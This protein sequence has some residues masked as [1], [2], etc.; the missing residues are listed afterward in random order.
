MAIKGIL[1]PLPR[2][3]ITPAISSKLFFWQPGT[4]TKQNAYTDETLATPLSNPLSADSAGLFPAIYLDP[5]L[6]YKVALY[7]STETND[8]PTGT[9]TFSQDNVYLPA[10]SYLFPLVNGGRLTLTSATPVTTADVSAATTLF[11]TPYQGN[12]L[13][14]Y[15]S[16]KTAWELLTFSEISIPLVGLTAS[17]P[18]DVWAYNNSGTAALELTA[19]TS[20]TA[21]AT[22]LALQDGVLVKSGTATRRYLGTVY[23]DAT[24][25][26]TDDTAAKRYLWNYYHRVRRSLRVVDATASWSY[27]TNTVRQANGN[28]ANQV[29]VVVGVAEA[30]LDLSQQVAMTNTNAAWQAYAS[31]GEDSTTT[32]ATG[33]VL[34]TTTGAGGTANKYDLSTT[35]LVKYPAIGRHFYAWV[36]ASITAATTT[37]LGTNGALNVAGITGSIEG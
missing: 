2:L 37:W 25:G 26:Q 22:A 28:P 12:R 15:N 16:T 5:A 11:F 33:V 18:Y 31:I 13:A 34:T 8:P 27:S 9:P 32:I 6:G 17:T 21:R 36:E 7:P 1:L 10:A 35:R 19:W 20:A 29:D 23:I 3:G 4:T 14:L 30:L 24:G